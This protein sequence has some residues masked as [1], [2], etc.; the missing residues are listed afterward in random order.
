[1]YCY[2]LCDCVDKWLLLQV[3]GRP[4]WSAVIDGV[5]FATV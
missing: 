1:M 3:G 5:D 2:I 4:M